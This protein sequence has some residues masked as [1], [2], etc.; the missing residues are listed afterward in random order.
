MSTLLICSLTQDLGPCVGNH[1][2]AGKN[3]RML[4]EEVY[5]LVLL[6]PWTLPLHSQRFVNAK[7]V[8]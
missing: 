7:P 1:G 2:K 8:S 6:P 5:S 3:L 4:Q